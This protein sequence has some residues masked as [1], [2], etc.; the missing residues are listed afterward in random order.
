MVTVPSS[1]TPADVSLQLV[2]KLVG[3]WGAGHSCVCSTRA[4]HVPT[5]AAGRHGECTGV[6]T[7]GC[8]RPG[9]HPI[10]LGVH[11]RVCTQ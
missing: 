4:Q 3:N 11:G 6:C 2:S 5:A 1:V 8:A 10:E 7:A 9:V